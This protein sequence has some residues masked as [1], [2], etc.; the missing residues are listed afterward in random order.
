MDRRFALIPMLV[1]L[2]AV[3]QQCPAGGGEEEDDSAEGRLE[4]SDWSYGRARKTVNSS[5]RVAV[6]FRVANRGKERV[7]SIELEI[8]LLGAMGEQVFAPFRTRLGSLAPGETRM[9][10]AAQDFVPDFGSYEIQ[11]KYSVGGKAETAAWVGSTDTAQPVP[12]SDRLAKGTASIVTLGEEL[13][14]SDKTRGMYIF[15]VRVR[16][17]GDKPATGL[18]A[19]ANFFGDR[20][21]KPIYSYSSKLGDGTMKPGETRIFD[22]RAQGVPRHLAYSIKV[23][24]DETPIEEQLSG[25]D[26]SDANEFQVSRFRFARTGTKKEDLS[27]RAEAFNNTG[28]EIGKAVVTFKFFGTDPKDPKSAGKEV[29]KHSAILENLKAGEK[30]PLEFVLQKVPAFSNYEISMD[31][32]GG[33]GA[34][35]SGPAAGAA[36]IVGKPSFSGADT[37]EV[38]LERLDTEDDGSVQVM[39]AAR[40]GRSKRAENVV[41]TLAFLDAKGKEIAKDDFRFAVGFEPGEVQNFVKKVAGAKGFA[42]CVPTVRFTEKQV[43]PAPGGEAGAG[44]AEG[45]APPGK[46]E[47]GKAE[48]KDDSKAA[49][50]SG[51][52]NGEGGDAAKGNG[53]AKG[54]VASKTDASAKGGAATGD[55]AKKENGAPKRNGRA[56]DEAA[57]EGSGSAK[58][59][60]AA[61]EK[62]AERPAGEGQSPED[63]GGTGGKGKDGGAAA[64][65]K[66]G[67]TIIK[68]ES[69]PME[70]APEGGLDLP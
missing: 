37:V 60:K 52:A 13:V 56:K 5:N 48:K 30:R 69:K 58:S 21:D 6:S 43:V 1:L 38:M 10:G 55:A 59:G 61:Q 49:G 53:P 4:V 63:A 24:C 34:G 46:P 51:A 66:P 18:S 32:A 65:E 47:A 70:P 31:L 7:D 22:I 68:K 16:N 29:A 27:V 39:G 26:F 23:K 3:S 20:K 62:D 8:R 44:E 33:A 9:A 12:K 64:K 17:Q 15:R 25:G 35:A 36:A 42:K 40:N 45:A 67:K 2:G 41:V 14:W 57:G 50:K 11:A 19:T 54:G 28:G